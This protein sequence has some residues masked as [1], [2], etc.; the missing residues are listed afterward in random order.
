MNES[1]GH[2]APG[3]KRPG[4][5]TPD[6]NSL[7]AVRA[8]R[9]RIAHFVTIAKRVGYGALTISIVAFGVGLANSFPDWLVTLSI[10]TLGVAV[11]V[12]PVPIVLGYG[13][14]AAER[15]ERQAGF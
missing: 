3:S 13:V 7:V 10:A 9:A 4:A 8:R 14:K 6:P 12:L 2:N 5:G 11:F 15:E 1:L